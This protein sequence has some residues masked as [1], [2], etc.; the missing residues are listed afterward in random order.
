[1]QASSQ[2]SRIVYQLSQL[3]IRGELNPGEKLAEIPLAER[4]GVSR[5]PVRQALTVL[6]KEG[7]L[8]RGNSGR[9]YVVRRFS[10]E[11]I[12]NAIEVRSVLEGLAAREVAQKR[13]PRGLLRE[14]EAL[15]LEAGEVIEKIEARGATGEL[16]ETYFSLNARFHKAIIDGAN[17]QALANALHSTGKIPF[18]S[19]GSIARYGD[20]TEDDSDTAKLRVRNLLLSHMQHQDLV[21]AITGAEPAR[22]ESLMREHALL[23]IRNLHLRDRG[24]VEIGSFATSYMEPIDHLISE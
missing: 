15:V 17:N 24:Q 5:T 4:F 11:E 18:V 6:E 23:G 16:T 13:T 1:M 21:E 3:I 7:L 12:L 9:S 20:V 8:I 14:L 22:A 19:V 10:L 2:T